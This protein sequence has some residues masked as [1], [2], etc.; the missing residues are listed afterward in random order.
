MLPSPQCHSG[1]CVTFLTMIYD[2]GTCYPYL[3]AVERLFRSSP[4]CYSKGYVTCPSRSWNGYSDSL[5]HDMVRGMLPALSAMEQQGL[6]F[7]SSV[8]LWMDLFIT[9]KWIDRKGYSYGVPA[10]EQLFKPLNVEC[11]GWNLSATFIG[12]RSCLYIGWLWFMRQVCSIVA[13][14]RWWKK[15]E[16]L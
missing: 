6:L 8:P 15:G 7:Y 16:L 2:G 10:H 11:S 3:V 12:R 5:H 13:V 1:G 4:P 9:C 14:C